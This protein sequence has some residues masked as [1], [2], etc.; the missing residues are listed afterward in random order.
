MRF[1]LYVLLAVFLSNQGASAVT[2][3]D[4]RTRTIDFPSKGLG[5]FYIEDGASPF[6]AQWPE[7]AERKWAKGR[8]IVPYD[9]IIGVETYWCNGDCLPDLRLLKSGDIQIL[10]VDG[11]VL[12]H[13]GMK[14]ICKMNGL[15]KLV[16]EG[17]DVDDHDLELVARR[18]PALQ[19][20]KIGYTRVTDNAL[21]AVAKM[22]SLRKLSLQRNKISS[23]GVA[24]L[25]DSP[26]LSELSLK[27]TK[28][29]DD[30]FAALTKCKRL[31]AL[32]LAKTKI[33]DKGVSALLSM[34]TLRKLDLSENKISDAAVCNI[35]AKLENLEEL[36]LSGTQVT[37]KGV[38]SLGKLKHLR[39]LWLRDLGNV[40]DASVPSL[41]GHSKMQDLEL[42]KTN[43]SSNGVQKLASA[44][45]HSEV[46]SHA[47]CK[48]RKQ[49]RVN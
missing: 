17:T 11:S 40:S 46:H 23:A 13:A 31:T 25:A 8:V 18:M 49:S 9:A 43:I 22:R 4:S 45:P 12:T 38:I 1:L 30:V 24:R 42:Q 27:E 21:D 15:R 14:H 41:I 35:L 48:C 29:D 10:D 16:L 34:R 19:E 28:V 6:L 32:N 20:L 2:S 26:G 44:L 33:S 5:K 7:L 36:N 3:S 37:D 47:L 39:K